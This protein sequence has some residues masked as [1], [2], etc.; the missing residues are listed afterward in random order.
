VVADFQVKFWKFNVGDVTESFGSVLGYAES[1]CES[2]KLECGQSC[3]A[4]WGPP[5]KTICDITYRFSHPN[6][7]LPTHAPRCISSQQLLNYQLL[8]SLK[9][10]E[11][12]ENSRCED[13]ENCLNFCAWNCCRDRIA[14]PTGNC[15]RGRTTGNELK[16][17]PARAIDC[18]AAIFVL[19]IEAGRGWFELTGMM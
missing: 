6:P 8:H 1:A 18:F 4:R 19:G 10:A 17:R 5:P 16:S 7:I 2:N 9:V 14:T 13:T 11:G 3:L 15:V 12:T